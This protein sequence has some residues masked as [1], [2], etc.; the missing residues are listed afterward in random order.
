MSTQA[1]TLSVVGSVIGISKSQLPY[2]SNERGYVKLIS[3]SKLYVSL[4]WFIIIA[5]LGTKK[6]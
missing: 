4:V 5:L 1:A 6:F 3:N 2:V